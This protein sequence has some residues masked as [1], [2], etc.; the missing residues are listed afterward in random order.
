MPTALE[1]YERRFVSVTYIGEICV[2]HSDRTT[3]FG[4]ESN[5]TNPHSDCILQILQL[6][7]LLKTPVGLRGHHCASTEESQ[8]NVTVFTSIKQG[9]F[10]KWL[11][12][13][14]YF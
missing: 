11:Q 3:V 1:H 13:W 6:L 8:Q 14:Q 7:T 10:Q 12:Q 2:M 4:E 9:T 5:S